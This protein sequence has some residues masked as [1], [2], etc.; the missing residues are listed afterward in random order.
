MK[1]FTKK[2]IFLGLLLGFAIGTVA[3][4]ATYMIQHVENFTAGNDSSIP[5]VNTNQEISSLGGTYAETQ[6]DM[7]TSTTPYGEVNS[8]SIF[9][10]FRKG[11]DPNVD[12]NSWTE[13]YLFSDFVDNTTTP[14][15]I[16]N[17]EGRTIYIQRAGIELTGVPTSTLQMFLG[18]STPVGV[19]TDSATQCAITDPDTSITALMDNILVTDGTLLDATST[20]FWSEAYVADDH[21]YGTNIKTIPVKAGE[22]LMLYASTTDAD[23]D[24][25]ELT[26]GTEEF[27]GKIYLEYGFWE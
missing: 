3:F 4:G 19:P 24:L 23:C 21:G 26:T 6:D 5:N 27:D 17:Q 20:I 2:S 16:Q 9:D 14:V 11:D 8:I 10:R 7:A 22:Y 1:F 13:K 15:L 18:T 25:G 12:Q